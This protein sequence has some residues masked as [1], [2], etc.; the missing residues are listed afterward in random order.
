MKITLNNAKGKILKTAKTV[1]REDIEVVPSLEK[2]NINANGTYTVGDGYAGI[3]EVVVSVSGGVTEEVEEW[4][5]TGI[6]IV[7]TEDELAGTWVF[8]DIVNLSPLASSTDFHV[9]FTYG[10]DNTEG[11]AIRIL[12]GN[13][14]EIDYQHYDDDEGEDVFSTAYY[15]LN[16]WYSDQTIHITSKLSDLTDADGESLLAWLKANATK[17]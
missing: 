15:G 17:Q 12:G 3:G 2:K 1:I 14:V 4:N 9:N 11:T 6:V 7:P 5:G 16:G 8:K 10:A 13:Y